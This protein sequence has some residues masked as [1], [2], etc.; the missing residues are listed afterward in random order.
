VVVDGGIS[1]L[2]F[3]DLFSPISFFGGSVFFSCTFCFW[4][5]VLFFVVAFLIGSKFI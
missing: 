4:E 2:I 1:L 5:A 3:I